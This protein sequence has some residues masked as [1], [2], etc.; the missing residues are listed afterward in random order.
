MRTKKPNGVPPSISTFADH[1]VIRPYNT[2]QRAIKRVKPGEND[3]DI[4]IARAEQALAQLSPE[5]EGWMTDDCDR[6]ERAR[7]AIRLVGLSEDA[8]MQLLCAARDIVGHAP[9]IG[10]PLAAQA[11]ESLC[12]L[13]E[14]APNPALIPLSLIDKHVDGIRA[15]IREDVRSGNQ[16]GEELA[17]SLRLVASEFLADENRHRPEYLAA[18]AAPPVAEKF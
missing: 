8:R 13:V 1:E 10:Y 6:L 14:L 12:Q 4:V 9:M 3:E 17:R 7:A 18:M 16:L 15:I 2:L 11:A 5:F